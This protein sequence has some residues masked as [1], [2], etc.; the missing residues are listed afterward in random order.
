MKADLGCVIFHRAQ[1][2]TQTGFQEVVSS[3]TPVVHAFDGI[4]DGIHREHRRLLDGDMIIYCMPVH[5][6]FTEIDE[7]WLIRYQCT[8]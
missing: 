4:R 6:K 8:Q 1:R 3:A 5:T 2:T 7:P